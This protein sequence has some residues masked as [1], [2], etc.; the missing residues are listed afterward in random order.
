MSALPIRW[1]TILALLA[2]GA[3]P[4]AARA[5][6][7]PRAPA[8]SAAPPAAP[9]T[10]D[11]GCDEAVVAWTTAASRRS[12][13][14]ITASAC[15][16]GLI[17]LQVAGAGCDYEIVRQRGFQR[18]ADGAFGV[19]PIANLDWSQAPEPMKKGLAA[20]VAGLEQDPSLPIRAGSVVRSSERGAIE[21]RALRERRI[22]VFGGVAMAVL[23]LS[24]LGA[25]WKRRRAR[26]K[27][28]PPR[29]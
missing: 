27:A 18:T 23:G 28:P 26:P 16:V 22:R 3:L 14:T 5:D 6:A 29:A 11:D 7:L 21:A 25:W 4:G 10:T 12:G 2:M 15:P 20:I 24:G 1:A 9:A 19:S 17:R 8:A 13:L